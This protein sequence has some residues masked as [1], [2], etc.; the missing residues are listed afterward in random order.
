MWESLNIERATIQNG[1]K[2]TA[3]LADTSRTRLLFN[4]FSFYLS[5]CECF[6][7]AGA[8]FVNVNYY[9]YVY[10]CMLS[11]ALWYKMKVQ[12]IFIP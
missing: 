8:L 7:A 1:T 9:M 6:F 4:I 12:K 3:Q 11:T 2:W 5:M 10:N